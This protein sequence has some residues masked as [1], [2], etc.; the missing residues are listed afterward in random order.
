V[1]GGKDLEGETFTAETD[2]AIGYVPQPRVYYDHAMRELKHHRGGV[3]SI[4]A[5]DTGLWIEAELDR[6]KAYVDMVLDLVQKGAL[7]WSSGSI[8][9]LVDR[10]NGLI[11]AWPI[12]EFSLTPTPAEPRTLGVELL[13]HMEIGEAEP[14]GAGD[15][16]AEAEQEPPSTTLTHSIEVITMTDEIKTVTVSDPRIDQLVSVVGELAQTVK[17]LTEGPS[18]GGTIGVQVVSDEAD[19]ALKGNP[20]SSLGEQLIAV[21]HAAFGTTDK[22]LLPLKAILGGNESVPSEG[23]FLVST[24]EAAGLDRKV[25]DSGVFAPRCS[26]VTI[27]A[28]ANAMTFYG[29]NEDS[30]ANGSRYGGVTGYRMGEGATI[31]QSTV[32]T[33]YTYTLRPKK[34]GAVA[35]LTDEVLQ[36]ARVLEQELMSAIPA[37]LAFM[38]D[39]DILQGV[40]AQ[41]CQGVL[42]HPCIVS[43]AKEVGQA[44]KT[45]VYENLINMWSR[46]FARGQY[47]WFVNQDCEPQL[48][49]LAHAVGAGVLPPN[50]VTYGP[51]GTLRIFGRPVVTTEFNA[52]LGT[53]GDILLADFSQYKL[54]NIG[55]VQAA[56]SMHVQFLTDQMCYRFTRRVDGMPTW[57]TVLTPYK[58]TGN[59]VSPFIILAVRA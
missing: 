6:H 52:T 54:A 53:T 50:F 39:D 37:E 49:L 23:G 8:G 13:K 38:L 9:H 19:R 11:K 31:T 58:G 27:P 3:V 46:R 20:F 24:A 12:A 15:A 36:D 41:G 5:D 1:F 4:K 28:G 32:Q 55:G 21:R 2:F 26:N 33:F 30:R 17:T 56:S 47:E 57:K 48:N 7:G 18:N 16:P 44:A 25:W 29:I 34:Y 10:D 45:I 51:D 14:E 22:R 59:T 35:Y 40:G 43:V 42:A